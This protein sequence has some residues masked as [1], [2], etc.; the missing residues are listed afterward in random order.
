MHE[1]N[2]KNNRQY[3]K[4]KVNKRKYKKIKK[5]SNKKGGGG[6]DTAEALEVHTK[7]LSAGLSAEPK[8]LS[9]KLEIKNRPK[10]S[11]A[12]I[13]LDTATKT[14]IAAGLKVKAIT[15]YIKGLKEPTNIFCGLFPNDSN[16]RELFRK[17]LHMDDICDFQGGKGGGGNPKVSTN[18]SRKKRK[19]LSYKF[20]KITS[21][22]N[23]IGGDNLF[24]QNAKLNK[25]IIA[26]K[27]ALKNMMESNKSLRQNLSQSI[28]MIKGR[29]Y[30]FFN[31]LE[32]TDLYKLYFTLIN[33]K[34]A[35]IYQILLD[36]N[37][38]KK[39]GEVYKSLGDTK[40]AL[41]SLSSE[42]RQNINKKY[43]KV[44]LFMGFQW[45]NYNYHAITD[46]Q[47]TPSLLDSQILGTMFSVDPD[48]VS[49][50][51]G[52]LSSIYGHGKI[53]KDSLEAYLKS[54]LNQMQI[55]KP[56]E[57]N[58]SERNVKTLDNLFK[59]KSVNSKDFEK[60]LSAIGRRIKNQANV[61]IKQIIKRMF[62]E[63]RKIYN[64]TILFG[65]N[66]H[67]NKD[68]KDYFYERIPITYKTI[69]NN[70]GAFDNANG[71]LEIKNTDMLEKLKLEFKNGL[72]Q[73]MH[74]FD[75]QTTNAQQ[76][77]D[78]M[79]RMNSSNYNIFKDTF[80]SI[81][82]L[83]STSKFIESAQLIYI[84]E[85]VLFKKIYFERA[86]PQHIT[87]EQ[88]IQLFFEKDIKYLIDIDTQN[89]PEGI[90]LNTNLYIQDKYTKYV[91]K[92][93]EDISEDDIQKIQNK[94]RLLYNDMDSKKYLRIKE[95]ML[96]RPDKGESQSR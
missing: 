92:M 78:F 60:T 4:M 36:L 95:L 3:N 91:T 63:S 68:C 13:V 43:E 49:T 18:K 83:I 75:I 86:L 8:G 16:L 46:I 88:S 26:L 54:N 67:N 23:Y 93:K 66:N 90:V 22:K 12:K 15:E 62:F 14:S 77:N 74:E 39:I 69:A 10:Q 51:F 34:N 57:I 32:L 61:D 64:S 21:K 50:M 33:I 89:E 28:P 84:I 11:L 24:P 38:Q 94:L 70:M 47:T 85:V 72:Y 76:M 30:N 6:G 81:E 58:E 41:E 1:I 40:K 71:D 96:S 27:I 53:D 79:E 73:H 17:Y 5:K 42:M 29:Y 19:K 56:N 44:D 48:S 37:L 7:G 55:N 82:Q 59:E 9:D 2:K 52:Y 25:R 65:K 80:Y 45:F 20:R 35:A 31:K 87:P